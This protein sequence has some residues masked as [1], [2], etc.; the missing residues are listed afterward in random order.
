MGLCKADA[1]KFFRDRTEA[2]T[3]ET[4]QARSEFSVKDSDGMEAQLA[5][6]GQIHGGGVEDPLFVGDNVVEG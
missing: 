2:N 4:E 6:A 1:E 5:Q 3:L